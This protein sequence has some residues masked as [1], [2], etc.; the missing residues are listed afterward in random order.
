[1]DAEKEVK[2]LMDEFVALDTDEQ[3]E[4]F[5]LKFRNAL[6]NRS[7]E[8]LGAYSLAVQEGAKDTINQSEALLQEYAFKETLS[9]IIPAVTWAYIAEHYFGKSRSWFSQR[10][11]G[12]N[13]NNREA[14]F[15]AEERITLKNALLDLS[16]RIRNSAHQLS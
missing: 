8:E 13:V 16:E 9:D 12:Y 4:A 1:M 15:S 3:R 6:S 10:M 7:Q 2:C 14:E 5:R 11:N